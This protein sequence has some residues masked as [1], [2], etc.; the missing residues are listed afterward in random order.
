MR[1]LS[2]LLFSM[3][4]MMYVSGALLYFSIGE[5]SILYETYILGAVISCR[6]LYGDCKHHPDVFVW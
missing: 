4:A 3:L 2:V 6:F 5:E 1:R